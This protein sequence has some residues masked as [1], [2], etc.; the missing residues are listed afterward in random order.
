[1]TGLKPCL[2]NFYHRRR[3]R[4]VSQDSSSAIA[5]EGERSINQGS[6]IFQTLRK[7]WMMEKGRKSK[8]FSSRSSKGGARRENFWG[9]WKLPAG[10]GGKSL[11]SWGEKGFFLPQPADILEEKSRGGKRRT[12]MCLGW[13]RGAKRKVGKKTISGG[14][15]FYGKPAEEEEKQNRETI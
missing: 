2:E 8:I 12:A 6:H 1:M 7:N 11:K 5:G 10:K 3:N 13:R 4:A 15:P 14:A 9:S